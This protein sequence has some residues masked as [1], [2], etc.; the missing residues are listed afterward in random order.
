M[1][2]WNR[3]QVVQKMNKEEMILFSFK[4]DLMLNTNMIPYFIM[5]ISQG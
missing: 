3:L 4:K 5:I 2:I 1:L